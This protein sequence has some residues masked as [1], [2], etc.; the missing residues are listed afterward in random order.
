MDS[1]DTEDAKH[2]GGHAQD[3]LEAIFT[4]P[5]REAPR[6]ERNRMTGFRFV[7]KVN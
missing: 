5:L 4:V 3:Q 2:I 7:A 1:F 6:E